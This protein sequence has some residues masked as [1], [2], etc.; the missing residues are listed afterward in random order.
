MAIDYGRRRVGVAMTDPAG[1]IAQPFL[2]IENSSR[3]ALIQ[4]LKSIIEKNGV[5]I[6]IVGNPLSLKGEPTSIGEEISKFV[7]RLKR[8]VKIEVLNWDERFT[9]RLAVKVLKDHRLK[10]YNIDGISASLILED[11]LESKIKSCRKS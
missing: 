5:E 8:D 4:K 3:G 6:V 2:T 10:P 11:F 9:S 1:I 7:Q